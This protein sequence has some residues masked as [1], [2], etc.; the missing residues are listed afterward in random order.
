MDNEITVEA[1]INAP[2]EK[3][4]EAWTDPEHIT[5]WCFASNDWHAPTSEND[6]RVGGKFKTRMESKDGK[7]GFDFEGT[8]TRVDE[9]KRVEYALDDGR[10][11]KVEFTKQEDGCKI[12]ESFEPEN[13]NS[14]EVQRN[15]WQAI[16]DNF[17]KYV[18]NKHH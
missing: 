9:Y 16:L 10:L 4:W 5:K 18:E 8:Y 13:E 3:I 15:G 17:K 6:L 11:V 7:E 14:I 1:H 12:V 2:I